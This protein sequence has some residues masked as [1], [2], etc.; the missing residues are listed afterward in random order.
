MTEMIIIYDFDGTLTP[1]PFPKFKILEKAGL[2]DGAS[3]TK[4][5]EMAKK[6]ASQENLE[7]WEAI[8]EVYFKIIK[9]ANLELVDNNFC[10]GADE[11]TYN[12]GVTDFLRFF[13][14]HHTNNYLISSGLKVYLEKT[15]VS[16][17][18]KKIYATTLYYNEKKEFTKIRYLMSNKKKVEAIKEIIKENKTCKNIIYIGDGLSDYDAMKYIKE[19]GGTSILL[20]HNQKD[21]SIKELTDKGV[22]NFVTKA[23]FSLDR[24]LFQYVKKLYTNSKKEDKI[25][26]GGIL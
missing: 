18:F 7:F 22:T 23:D 17:Y 4:F 3:N 24:E 14:E 12:K 8:Y 9:E 6:K 25:N 20:Y 13:Q 21:P 16:K 5:L 19:N 1:Y 11:I 26:N 10:L 15:K 2:L